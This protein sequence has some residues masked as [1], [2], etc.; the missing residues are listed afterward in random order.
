LDTSLAALADKQAITEALMRYCH[1]VDRCD[2]ALL[3]SAF[4][5]DGTADYGTTVLA[6]HEFCEG[7]VP[8]LLAMQS[9]MH[10]LSNMLISLDGDRAR[11]ISNC[12]AYHQTD[13]PDGATELIAGGRYLDDLE[14]RGGEWR[15]VSR[16]YVLD[17]SRTG[18]SSHGYDGLF[19]QLTNRGA[20]YPD[21]RWYRRSAGAAGGRQ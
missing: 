4:W 6:S 13:G 21:D 19:A 1:G 16:V 10:N 9:T 7:L 12:V 5:E 8:L 11:A 18:P 20:R 15:I 17:W 14:K 2:L 3:K